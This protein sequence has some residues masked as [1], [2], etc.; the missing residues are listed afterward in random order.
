MAAQYERLCSLGF[1]IAYVDEH[2]LSG[3]ITEVRDGIVSVASRESL[4]YDREL[5][6]SAAIGPLPNW[7]GPG[8]HPGTEL[9]D[10]LSATQPGTYLLVGH[11]GF[12]ADE[13]QHLRFDWG[14]HDDILQQRSRERRMFADIEIVDYC[15]NA[16]ITLLRYTEVR[17]E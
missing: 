12:K 3:S 7:T 15:E 17:S 4:I 10:H 16:G 1:N 2:M 6:E 5:A 8:P 11:P 13:M 14:G 9:A